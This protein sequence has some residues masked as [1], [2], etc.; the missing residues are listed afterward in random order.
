MDTAPLG[1]PCLPPPRPGRFFP[2]RA[3]PAQDAGFPPSFGRRFPRGLLIPLCVWGRRP[4]GGR[5]RKGVF[6]PCGQ[7]TIGRTSP[8]PPESSLARILRIPPLPPR[9]HSMK[10]RP[11]CRAKKEDFSEE[12]RKRTHIPET[13]RRGAPSVSRFQAPTAA[14][15]VALDE[16]SART[17]RREGATRK[18]SKQFIVWGW[19]L[20]QFVL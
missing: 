4:S 7:S 14:P 11:N 19:D 5:C 2:F 9:P 18:T 1:M 20:P 10:N 15:A 8:L 3:S 13:E 12:E 16:E 6:M 17:V